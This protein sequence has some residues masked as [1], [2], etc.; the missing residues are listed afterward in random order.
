MKIIRITAI[1]CSGCLVMKKIWREIEQEY[2]N[3][4]ITDYDYDFD[5]EIVKN[6]EVGK[7]LP[8]VIFE[9]NDKQERLI[10]EKKKEEIINII[11]SM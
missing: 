3:L 6:Y 1:W 5:N 11:E 7:I 8:V 2:P 9:K 10:G 4:E